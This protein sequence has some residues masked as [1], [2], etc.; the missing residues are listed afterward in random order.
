MR[1]FC[2][3]VCYLFLLGSACPQVEIPEYRRVTLRPRVAA[4]V[5]SQ[6]QGHS[7]IPSRFPGV[8]DKQSKCARGGIPIPQLLLT[9]GGV[10]HYPVFVGGIILSEFEK[11]VERKLWLG[12]RALE[13]FDVVAVP[14]FIAEL[15]S[16]GA[17]NMGEDIA[18]VIVMLDEIT[19]GETNA[20]GHAAISIDSVHR[21]RGHCIVLGSTA[22]HT[23]YSA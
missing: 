23:L 7:E 8:F 14:P 15:Q 12:P 1:G 10:I 2:I 17:S 11:V 5:I 6:T 19:L 4:V 16:M 13:G 21:N 22:Q 9:R 18:P 3:A 20:I